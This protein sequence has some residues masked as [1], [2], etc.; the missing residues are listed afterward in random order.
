MRKFLLAI[1]VILAFTA[2]SAFATPLW[3]EKIW[4][5]GTDGN[6]MD[7]TANSGYLYILGNSYYSIKVIATP[8]SP[9][10]IS[11]NWDWKYE[12]TGS[13]DSHAVNQFSLELGMVADFTSPLVTLENVAVTSSVDGELTAWG[14]EVY[15]NTLQVVN[16]YTMSSETQWINKDAVFTVSFTTNLGPNDTGSIGLFGYKWVNGKQ[17]IYGYGNCFNIP[18][19]AFDLEQPV[20]E[21][22]TIALGAMGLSSLFAYRRF[23][24]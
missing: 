17:Q 16:P 21:P 12:L 22:T 19:P 8:T 13:A 23:R 1:V 6:D 5:V 7:L 10:S 2:V 11:T 3:T 24:K 15:Q 9:Y 14:Y 4:T 18:V 20:P